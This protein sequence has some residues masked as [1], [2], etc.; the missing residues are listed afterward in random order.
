[1]KILSV[2][3]DKVQVEFKKEDICSSSEPKLKLI[4]SLMDNLEEKKDKIIGFK[5]E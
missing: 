5:K 4:V 1:M 2:D 3:K